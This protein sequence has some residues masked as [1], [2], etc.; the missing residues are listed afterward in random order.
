[1]GGA[2]ECPSS[3]LYDD[4]RRLGPGTLP[5]RGCGDPPQ[6]KSSSTDLASLRSA[7]SKPSVNEA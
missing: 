5:D 3:R 7:V 1:M 2:T 4:T 6:A